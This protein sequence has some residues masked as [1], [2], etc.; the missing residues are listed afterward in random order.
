MGCI[1][2]QELISRV[3]DGD[4]SPAEQTELNRHLA[5]CSECRTLYQSFLALSEAVGG[6]LEEPPA[7]LRANVMA[8]IRRAEIR[9]KNRLSRPVK[10]LLTT[11][12]CLA[13]IVGLS[14]GSGLLRPKGAAQNS[15]VLAGSNFSR[16]LYEASPETAAAAADAGGGYALAERAEKEAAAAVT[17]DAAQANRPAAAKSAADAAEA[18]RR[19]LSGQLSAGELLE[20][21]GGSQQRIDAGDLAGDLCCVLTVAGEDG[22]CDVSVYVSGGALYYTDPVSGGILLADAGPEVLDSLPDG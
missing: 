18:P 6:D 15:T 7:S 13:V 12:A 14:L 9:K 10:V 20:L 4:L 11:A 21:L 16:S 3:L 8:E 5:V 1:E 17:G 2:Y 19:D 22:P